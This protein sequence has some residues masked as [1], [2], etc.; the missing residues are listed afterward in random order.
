MTSGKFNPRCD[1]DKQAIPWAT[2]LRATYGTTAPVSS[3]MEIALAIQ[4]PLY[5]KMLEKTHDMYLGIIM[6]IIIIIIIF[7]LIIIIIK[8]L[9]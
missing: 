5:L 9:F 1:S 8:T 4:W 3:C 2:S 6:I 7:F